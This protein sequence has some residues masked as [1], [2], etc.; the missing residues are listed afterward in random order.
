MANV[1]KKCAPL[2]GPTIPR[3]DIEQH[4][5]CAVCLTMYCEPISL[6][7]GHT[8]CRM[9]L[10][11]SLKR[12]RKKC[13]VCR[14]VCQLDAQQ[15]KE[16]VVIRDICMAVDPALYAARAAEVGP[17]IHFFTHGNALRVS[18]PSSSPCCLPPFGMMGATPNPNPT[19]TPPPPPPTTT[20]R[21]R[22][23]GVGIGPA[24]LLL[25]R[26]SVS[27]RRPQPAPIR[28]AIQAAGTGE[29]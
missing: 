17:C 5:I 18:A 24:H 13:P 23:G 27:G 28:A 3:G 11:N 21:G 25:Q 26:L 7:C 8:A 20:G 1:S 2:L 15:A 9:C 4:V 16:N 10:L 6:I 12:N 14:A 19:P 29:G 22:E